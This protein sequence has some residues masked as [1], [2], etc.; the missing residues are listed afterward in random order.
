VDELHYDD[1]KRND[2][3]NSTESVN[4]DFQTYSPEG[5]AIRRS[6]ETAIE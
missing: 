1:K 6:A 2:D 5:A 4:Y 3:E